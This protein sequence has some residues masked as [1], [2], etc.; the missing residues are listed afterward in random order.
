MMRRRP[1]G[2]RRRFAFLGAGAAVFGAASFFTAAHL[3][4]IASA[5]RFREAALIA[6][7]PLAGPAETDSELG[8][9]SIPLSS[10]IRWLICC[11]RAY[12]PSIAARMIS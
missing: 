11:L 10:A 1:S 12:K 3:L 7:G 9:L 4:R 2:L 5:I 6:R 8:P